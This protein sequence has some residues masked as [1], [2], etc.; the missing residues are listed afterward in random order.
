MVRAKVRHLGDTKGTTIQYIDRNV[1]HGTQ[2]LDNR[3]LVTVNTSQA[4]EELLRVGLHLYNR[5][6]SL[7]RY[8]DILHDEY[9]EHLQYQELQSRLYSKVEEIMKSRIPLPGGLPLS[10][11]AKLSE[12][13]LKQ[14]MNIELIK[15]AVEAETS[16]LSN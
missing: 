14:A 7:R 5:K 4:R 8:D 9:R 11:R 12:D 6:I 2:T 15:A 1:I 3:W 10:T 13:E 16:R